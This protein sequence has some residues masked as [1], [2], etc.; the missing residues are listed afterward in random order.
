M[1]HLWLLAL[2]AAHPPL[3]TRLHAPSSPQVLS[4]VF[5][6]S[7]AVTNLLLKLTNRVLTGRER[8]GTSRG[9]EL[10]TFNKLAAAYL[11]NSVLVPLIVYSF[12]MFVSQVIAILSIIVCLTCALHELS[13]SALAILTDPCLLLTTP[14]HLLLSLH[15]SRCTQL[16]LH[17]LDPTNQNSSA[18]HISLF[19]PRSCRR[20]H[21]TRRAGPCLQRSS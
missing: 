2:T 12:P 8:H 13:F 14:C 10:S 6:L 19:T 20:R 17:T 18:L 3:P 5:S 11:L 16:A 7:T 15:T 9:Q 21:G 1:A 4:V